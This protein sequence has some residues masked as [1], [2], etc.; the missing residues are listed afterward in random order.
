MPSPLNPK[1]FALIETMQKE[2]LVAWGYSPEETAIIVTAFIGKFRAAYL[3]GGLEKL[4]DEM[5]EICRGEQRY[6][7]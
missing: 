3:T 5:E 4:M 6:E 7:G 1:R 2:M